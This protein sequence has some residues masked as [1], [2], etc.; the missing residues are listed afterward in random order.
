MMT[1]PTPPDDNRGRTRRE[2]DWLRENAAAL[3]SS[4]RYVEL[5]G[6]PLQAFWAGTKKKAPENEDRACA[7][8]ALADISRPT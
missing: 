1:E 8:T 4:N 6:L 7:T 2:V 5:H 3:E